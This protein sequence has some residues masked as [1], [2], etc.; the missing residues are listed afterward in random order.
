[1]ALSDHTLL[2]NE[3]STN[4]LKTVLKLAQLP[5]S[6]TRSGCTWIHEQLFIFKDIE[7]LKEIVINTLSK[8]NEEEEMKNKCGH[9]CDKSYVERLQLCQFVEGKQFAHYKNQL[10]DDYL[11][12]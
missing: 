7:R 10:N 5:P 8:F 12:K 2:R 9:A 1:M 4:E 11:I 6:F 3:L